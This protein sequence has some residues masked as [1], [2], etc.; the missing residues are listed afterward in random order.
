MSYFR[1]TTYLHIRFVLNSAY[2]MIYPL[3][4]V[5][6]RGLG[7][8]MSVIAGLGATRAFAGAGLPFIVLYID[9]RGR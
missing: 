6:A 2:R 7:V 8:V 3:L 1:L 5:F 9:P 4:T